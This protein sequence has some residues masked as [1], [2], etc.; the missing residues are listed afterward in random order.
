MNT[1]HKS[2]GIDIGSV[3]VKLV[4]MDEGKVAKEVFEQ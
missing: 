3:S 4:L 1:A 2:L